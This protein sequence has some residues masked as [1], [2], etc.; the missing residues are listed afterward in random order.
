VR[1]VT[2][3]QGSQA[4]ERS[5]DPGLHA[6]PRCESG[7]DDLSYRH[8]DLSHVSGHRQVT[9][10]YVAALAASRKGVLATFDR[11]LAAAMTEHVVLI[12]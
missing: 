8:A 10:A 1:F 3:P 6:S 12:P 11:A 2:K 9:D 4:H 7:A 5:R